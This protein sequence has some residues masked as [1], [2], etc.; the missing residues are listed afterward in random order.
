VSAYTSKQILER[1]PEISYRQLNYWCM[2]G[3]F[4]PEQ[5]D[6]GSGRRRSFTEMD[7]R[8]FRAIGLVAGCLDEIGQRRNPLGTDFYRLIGLQVR[9]GAERVVVR[10]GDRVRLVVDLEADLTAEPLAAAS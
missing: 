4:G 8:V 10:L 9:D 1:C 2:L 6:L 5:K 7:L 3:L